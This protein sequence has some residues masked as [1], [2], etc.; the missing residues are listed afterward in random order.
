MQVWKRGNDYIGK[1]SPA[2]GRATR[3]PF[4]HP[5]AFLEAFANHYMNFVDTVKASMEGKKPSPLALDFPGVEEGLRGMLF[6]EALLASAKSKQ[7]WTK[8]KS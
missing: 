2:A 8:M 3:L 4:G 1:K 6:L 7:K 5:E